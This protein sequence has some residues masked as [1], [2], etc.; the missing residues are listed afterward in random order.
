MDFE[1]NQL[2]TTPNST[3]TTEKANSVYT[4]ASMFN[5]G[6]S[7]KNIFNI[8]YT[9]LTTLEGEQA[10]RLTQGTF[11]SNPDDNYTKY[12]L[13]WQERR[14]RADQINGNFD[15]EL[16]NQ[17]VNLRFG[18][19][20]A[21]ATLNQPNN[22]SYS[23]LD[24]ANVVDDLPYLTSQISNNISTKIA[25]KDNL[26]AFYL[27]NK[28]HFDLL[29]EDDFIDIGYSGSSKDRTFRQNKYYLSYSK[30]SKFTPDTQ[31]TADVETIYD[32]LVRPDISYNNRVLRVNTLSSPKDYFDAT[33]EEKNYYLSTFLKPLDNLE[34]LFGGR[35]V[36]LTQTMFLY[37]LDRDNPD[38]AKR[39]LVIKKENTI[40]VNKFYPSMSLKYKLDKD[41]HVDFAYSTT[42]IM[43]DLIEA[44]NGTYT[45][46]YDVADVVGNPNL[47][48]TEIQN[49]DLKYSHYYSDSE[50][51]KVGLYY[52]SLAKPIE[53]V[54]LNTSSLPRYSF[55]N[56]KNA[57]IYGIELDGRKS[58]NFIYDDMK[59]YYVSGNFT[60]SDSKVTLRKE[61]EQL[62]TTNGRQL[63]GL[64]QVVI[65]LGLS[66]ETKLRSVSL[67]YN[68]MG[69]RIRKVGQIQDAGTDSESRFPDYMEDPAAILD[70]IWIEKYKNGLSFKIKLGNI[71][72]GETIW[73][74][75]STS[76]ITNRFKVGQNYSLALSY[77]Y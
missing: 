37:D 1:T 76:T 30:G 22:Y 46:P 10:T 72:D 17:E 7:Y 61:Q 70:L 24:D 9:K 53:N 5:I 8:R 44:S 39:N 63:Q 21:K 49:Y 69:A 13:D 20:K 74:Q 51:I 65:N 31:M 43:P 67:A 52:K 18:I 71:L 3:G 19:E 62:Y 16:L 47:Q 40:L 14:L 27:K 12:Y 45:H 73:Y 55:D 38:F 33:V 32:E 11:G 77:K 48:N 58:L 50:N 66:Y 6:Y 56:S 25:S 59:N 54:M 36:D 23:Y 34:I 42:F 57:T 60:Y 75:G 64:S 41:N 68:K 15:Y 28:F 35:K 4:L 26:T 29:S 2:N